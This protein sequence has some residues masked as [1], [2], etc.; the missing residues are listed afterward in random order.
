MGSEPRAYSGTPTRAFTDPSNVP[1]RV[2][3]LVNIY[4]PIPQSGQEITVPELRDDIGV[5][6]SGEGRDIAPSKGEGKRTNGE[7]GE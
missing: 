2:T 3:F 5:I 6:R 1:S 4:S 7:K